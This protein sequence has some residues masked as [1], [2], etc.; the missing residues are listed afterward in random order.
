MTEHVHDNF[1]TDIVKRWMRAMNTCN[2]DALDDLVAKNVI[3][4][5]GFSAPYGR[6]LPAHKELIRHLFLAVPDWSSEI[7]GITVNGDMVTVRHTGRGT[8]PRS[9]ATL[10]RVPTTGSKVEVQLVSTVRIAEEK[11]VEHWAR[12][13][14]EQPI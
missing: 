5:S 10:F 7:D 13:R 2:V 1:L 11:I 9:M 12:S 14:P 8:L 6:G 3:D 4:H